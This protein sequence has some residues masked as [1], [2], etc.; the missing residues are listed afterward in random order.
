MKRLDLWNRADRIPEIYGTL[1]TLGLIAYFF[2]MYAIG[3]VHV[4]ELRLLNLFI[5]IAGIYKAIQQ[6][7]R[8]HGGHLNYFRGLAIGISTGTIGVS[9][10]ALF[11]LIYLKIDSNLM[12]T[13][14]ERGPM[15]QYLNEYIAAAVV[16]AEGVFS[17]LTITY[18][19]LNY[20]ETDKVA[21]P[22]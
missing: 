5:M 3:L 17:G 14:I 16:T 19:L 20:V 12:A 10:F 13:L 1:I 7:K 11:L 4:I 21:D 2:L 8:T 22:T 9:T 18:I 6:Y 15:G